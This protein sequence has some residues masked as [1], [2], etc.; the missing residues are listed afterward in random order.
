MVDAI[1]SLEIHI[2]SKAE[3]SDH[4][5]RQQLHVSATHAPH[6]ILEQHPFLAAAL[7]KLYHN[8]HF[9]RH[10][11]TLFVYHLYFDNQYMPLR[12]KG[13]RGKVRNRN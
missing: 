2:Q 5:L 6:H 4:I 10:S 9:E 11:A 8:S 13:G 3:Q 7:C 1:C 12:L